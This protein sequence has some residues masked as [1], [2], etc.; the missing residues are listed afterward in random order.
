MK[1]ILFLPGSL[2]YGHV[3][4]C[5]A[6]AD[7]FKFR[8]E[9][10]IF[11][12]FG[13][14]D[15]KIISDSGYEVFHVHDL[16]EEM[17]L[18]VAGPNPVGGEGPKAVFQLINDDDF[19]NQSVQDELDIIHNKSI[20]LVV[21][22]SRWTGNIAPL[23]ADVASVSIIQNYLFVQ[24]EIIEKVIPQKEAAQGLIH[25]LT[26]F[27]E[28]INN[29]RT[30]KDIKNVDGIFDLFLSDFNI[31]ATIEGYGEIAESNKGVLEYLGPFIRKIPKQI[32]EPDWMKELDPDKK[33]IY[34]STGG[35]R[36]G[37]IAIKPIIEAIM[38]MDDV[39]AVI[40]ASYANLPF[41]ADSLPKRIM[42]K[43]YVPGIAMTMK[44]DVVITHGGHTTIME[45]MS[46]GVPGLVTPYQPEQ[47][48]NGMQTQI[49][50]AG[51]VVTPEELNSKCIKEK[52]TRLLNEERF[53][54]GAAKMKKVISEYPGT[55]GAV[56]EILKTVK[57][58]VRKRA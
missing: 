18:K 48:F 33:V 34:V 51:L 55:K 39:Q 38:E 37:K 46:H 1:N 19:I 9:Y 47:L 16:S 43:P 14:R 21:Y 28:K 25:A 56:S 5:L 13:G 11:F 50:D 17:I 32:E 20:D 58:V 45:L 23:I 6:L 24:P 31:A 49:N 57:T 40:S 3:S 26:M 44:S 2:G 35:G 42:I 8:G 29:Y 54:K 30:Q 22:D 36:R 52:L 7:E 10:N 4:R 12:G 15:K 41:E 53:K 27:K